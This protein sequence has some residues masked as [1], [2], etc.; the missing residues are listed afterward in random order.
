MQSDSNKKK[1]TYR[2]DKFYQ[3]NSETG[4]GQI[5][6]TPKPITEASIPTETVD[7][8]SIHFPFTT[9]SKLVKC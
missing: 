7:L 6:S 3:I 9:M 2:F 8:P 5:Q 4:A 1:S